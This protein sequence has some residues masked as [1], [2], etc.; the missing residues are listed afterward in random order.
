MVLKTRK[1]F[2][3]PAVHGRSLS[4][5]NIPTP[6]LRTEPKTGPAV[7]DGRFDT[8]SSLR[9]MFVCFFAIST[10]VTVAAVFTTIEGRLLGFHKYECSDF[11]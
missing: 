9:I 1:D 11:W 10:V 7:I 3:R 8:K 2:L 5:R 4:P 6:C